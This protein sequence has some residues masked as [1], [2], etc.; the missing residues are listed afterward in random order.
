MGD[1]MELKTKCIKCKKNMEYSEMRAVP[2]QG[3]MCAECYANP[4]VKKPTDAITKS[5][6]I[7]ATKIIN[8]DKSK[9]SSRMIDYVCDKCRYKFSRGSHFFVEKC[10]YCGGKDFHER[11]EDSTIRLVSRKDY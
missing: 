1:K 7:Q 4:D 5:K 6:V 9:S 2:G 8:E 11:T 3:Y 10:P